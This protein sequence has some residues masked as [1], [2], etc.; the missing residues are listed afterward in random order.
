M[1]VDELAGAPIEDAG[2]RGLVG[3]CDWSYSEHDHH[4]GIDGHAGAVRRTASVDEVFMNVEREALLWLGVAD[5]SPAA[6]A[7]A[8]D[9]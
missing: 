2:R 6:V 4:V 3:N 9:R 1:P 7:R 5:G 8:P